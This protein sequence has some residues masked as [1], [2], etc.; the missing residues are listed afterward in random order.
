MKSLHGAWCT[1]SLYIQSVLGDMAGRR[2]SWDL[3][4]NQRAAS[5][6]NY[7]KG[8]KTLRYSPVRVFSLLL[9]RKL[10]SKLCRRNHHTPQVRLLYNGLWSW[11]CSWRAREDRAR[12]LRA[13]QQSTWT[14]TAMIIQLNPFCRDQ[15]PAVIWSMTVPKTLCSIGREQVK[16]IR[17]PI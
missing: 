2:F 1:K 10:K 11:K 12:E 6:W 9:G 4:V 3:H 16:A 17:C 13:G 15:Q 5:I 7:N 14:K 8:M